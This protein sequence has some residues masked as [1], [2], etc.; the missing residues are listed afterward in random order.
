MNIGLV[1]TTYNRPDYLVKCFESVKKLKLPTGDDGWNA[2]YVVDDGSHEETKQ[3]CREFCLAVNNTSSNVEAYCILKEKNSGI[4]DSIK[5]GAETAFEDKCDVV[6]NIDGDALVKPEAILRLI[7]LKKEHP[8][9]IVS[10]FNCITT[11]NP[12]VFEYEGHVLKHY[13]NG[14]NFCFNREEYKKYILPGLQ[15]HGNWDYNASV[16]HKKDARMFVVSK[17]SVVQHIGFKSSMGHYSVNGPDIAH[18]FKMLELPTVTLFGIDAHDPEGI[19]R[20]AEISQR[21]IEFGKVNIITKR[22]FPGANADEGRRNYSKFMIR[23][24]TKHFDTNHVLTIHSDGYVL[25]WGAWDK[26]WLEY[27]Y[28][29][30]PWDWYN[31]NMVG[32]GGFSLRSKKLC[33]ILAEDK[34]IQVFHPEDEMI[35]RRYRSYLE[36]THGIKFAPV[37][38]AKKFSIEAYGLAHHFRIYDGEFGFHGPHVSFAE[39]GIP[40][41][42]LPKRKDPP[43]NENPGR[44]TPGQNGK[45]V[46]RTKFP[47][48]LPEKFWPQEY[49]TPKIFDPKDLIPKKK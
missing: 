32:N 38:V 41:S 4:K 35:C 49:K 37:E 10:G 1:I 9:S 29:G 45:Y 24:L 25:N 39:Y 36:K 46:D 14:I 8:D 17:P 31:E 6:I 3:L 2:I 30:A 23:E 15:K 40:E 43:P 22:L 34:N 20:A 27:D 18:D 28:I 12:V 47:Y 7:A 48:F 26:R 44:F 16:L 21:T 11:H 5:I 42:M 33:E 19:L 13:C